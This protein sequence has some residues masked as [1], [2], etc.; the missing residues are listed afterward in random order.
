M[1]ISGLVITFDA[2]VNEQR[3]T[4]ES[5]R[6]IPEIELGDASG[7]KLAIVVDSDNKRR[8]QAIWDVVRGLPG[9]TDLSVAM[10]VFDDHQTD[11]GEGFVNRS[12]K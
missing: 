1:P 9:V 6:A 11:S 10:V 8:D 7:C 12:S 3:D 2:P 4:I 5:L